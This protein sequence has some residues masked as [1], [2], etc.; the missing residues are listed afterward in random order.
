MNWDAIS[1]AAETVGTIAVLITLMYLAVQ[2]KIGNKQREMDALRHNWDG[3]NRTCELFGETTEKASIVKR[4]RKSIESLSA[5]EC[6]VFEFL[7]IRTLNTI[8]GW[9]KVKHTFTPIQE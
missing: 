3:L 8:E 7:H 6:L 4:G 1:A 9:E 2:L 5:E